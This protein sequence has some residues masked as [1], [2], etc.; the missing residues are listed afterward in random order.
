M[1]ECKDCVNVSGKDVTLVSGTCIRRE[2]ASRVV[3]VCTITIYFFC[4]Y[5]GFVLLEV[6]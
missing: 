2:P 4:C 3:G 5:L 1:Y 6:E